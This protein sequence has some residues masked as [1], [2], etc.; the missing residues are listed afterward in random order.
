MLLTCLTLVIMLAVGYAYLREG[1]FTACTMFVNVLLAGLVAFNFW[2]PIADLLDP[3]FGDSFLHGYEDCICLVALFALT[4]GA[5]RFCT[6]ALGRTELQY[7]Q[8]LRRGGGFL[9]G[10][11][12][13]YLVSGFLLCVLQTLPWHENFMFFDPSIDASSARGMR[14]ILPPDRVWLALMCRAGA[15]TF[16]NDE[17]DSALATAD[18][19][20][21]S[22][23][24][25]KYR[26]FDKYGSFELRYARYRRT[27]DTRA[28]LE[29]LGEFDLQLNRGG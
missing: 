13:G 5:L 4:L 3:N 16:A 12:I 8:W 9:F 2:E 18:S 19:S 28:P 14:R 26:T 21:G 7:P 22:P 27:G 10:M 1:V 23:A 24:I 15:Y 17:D 20:E 29:Y 6:N 25:K 11:G